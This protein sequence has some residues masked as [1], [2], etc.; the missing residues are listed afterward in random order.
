MTTYEM[1]KYWLTDTLEAY[2]D[3]QPGAWKRAFIDGLMERSR[4][5]VWGD[6]D[7][8]LHNLA[9]LEYIA[10]ERR[11]KSAVCQALH[12]SRANYGQTKEKAVERLCVLAFGVDGIS[13]GGG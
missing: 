12:I 3:T 4:R 11:A 5:A 9:V 1:G 7:K 6:E 13:W 10:E 8:A 2:R